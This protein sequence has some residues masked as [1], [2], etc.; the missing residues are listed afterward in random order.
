MLSKTNRIRYRHTD[1]MTKTLKITPHSN[2]ISVLFPSSFVTITV[3]STLGS[4][5]HCVATNLQEIIQAM[6]Q[7]LIHGTRLLTTTHTKR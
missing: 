7:Y 1:M 5:A 2:N 6:V 3:L 4:T